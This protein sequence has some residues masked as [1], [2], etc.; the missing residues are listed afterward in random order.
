MKYKSMKPR[1]IIGVIGSDGDLPAGVKKIAE[2]IGEDIGQNNCI[3]ICGGRGGVMEAVC[4]GSK[5]NGAAAITVGIL[6]SSD[7]NTANSFIDIPLATGIGYARNALVA[8]CSDAVIVINGRAGTL[9]EACLALNYKKPVIAVRGSGG[10]AD[11]LED[12]LKRM[13]IK[14]IKSGVHS[15]DAKEAVTLAMELIRNAQ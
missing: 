10:V 4:R 14:N 3:L 8:S 11:V 6:P 15:V 5:N 2:K 7:K 13:G 1:P 9:S 12:E